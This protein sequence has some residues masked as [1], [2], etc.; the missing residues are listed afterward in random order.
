MAKIFVSMLGTTYQTVEMRL[1][2]ELVL[3]PWIQFSIVEGGGFSLQNKGNFLYSAATVNSTMDSSAKTM[4]DSVVDSSP[5]RNAQ[6]LRASS[7]S[8][9]KAKSTTQRRCPSA[10][11]DS[12]SSRKLYNILSSS[13]PLLAVKVFLRTS[14]NFLYI[15]CYLLSWMCIEI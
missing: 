5:N 14:I 9:L 15:S 7:L 11:G 8:P 2:Q 3:H 12:R 10:F 6:P 13:S 1:W 4:E